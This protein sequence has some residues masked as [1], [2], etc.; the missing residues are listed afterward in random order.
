[1]FIECSF[2]NCQPDAYLF[3]H[4]NPR[5]LYEELNTLAKQ[6]ILLREEA[7]QDALLQQEARNADLEMSME[8]KSSARK[9]KR[10]SGGW[11]DGLRIPGR[12]WRDGPRDIMEETEAEF[13]SGSGAVGDLN[14]ESAIR[15][16]S[17]GGVSP[18]CTASDP[19]EEP[20]ELTL[21]QS[22][23]NNNLNQISFQQNGDDPEV[24]GQLP[25]N[26]NGDVKEMME[27]KFDFSLKPLD[28]LLIVVNHVKD[29]LEDDV[30]TVDGI[31]TSLLKLESEKNLGC[32]FIMA[33][34]GLTIFI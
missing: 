1:M 13:L 4:L 24:L 11:S 18:K 27:L 3:G 31:H 20:S 2:D 16:N 32:T 21:S 22:E 8:W 14:D 5:H 7:A 23:F 26:G 15:R 25:T 28:G 6:V 9:R 10:M 29:T 34:K 17:A 19:E 12:R 30:D 33:K